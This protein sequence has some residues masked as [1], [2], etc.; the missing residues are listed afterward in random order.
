MEVTLYSTHCPKCNVLQKKL[1]LKNIN[2]K[3]IDDIE[4][5]RKKH[6]MQAP[7]LEVDGETMD[8]IKAIGWVDQQ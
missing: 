8:F 4:I 5:M 1:E 6:F 3:E 7:M 2:Y